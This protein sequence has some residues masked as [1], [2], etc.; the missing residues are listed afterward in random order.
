MSWPTLTNPGLQ[1]DQGTGADPTTGMPVQLPPIV[2]FFKNAALRGHQ[3]ALDEMSQVQPSTSDVSGPVGGPQTAT[4]VQ[5]PDAKVPKFIQPSF[6]QAAGP[7]ANGL[8]QPINPAAET[9]AGALLHILAAAGQGALAG[10]GTGNPAAGADR[11]REIPIHMAQERQQLQTGSLANQTSQAN[12]RAFPLSIAE[13]QAAIE[14][15][16]AQ[17]RLATQGAAGGQYQL[18]PGGA[19]YRYQ[20]TGHFGQPVGPGMSAI[21]PALLRPKVKGVTVK[22]DDGI[23]RAATQNLLTGEIL[24]ENQQVI[25]NAQIF[26]GSM[27]P[28]STTENQSQDL[29]GNTTNR[30]TTTPVLPI[31]GGTAASSG[32]RP[33]NMVQ[34]SAGG[35]LRAQAGT[36]G[37]ARPSVKTNTPAASIAQRPLPP[38]VEQRLT[39]SGLGP[40][41]QSY[42][43]GLLNYQGQL[44][45]PRA[46]N[47]APTLATLTSIDPSFNAANYDANKKTFQDYTPGGTVGKQA[48]AFNTAI[49]HLDML[50][51]A[52]TALKNFDTPLLNKITNFVNVQV[53]NSPVTTFK[54]IADAVDGEVSKTFK[55]T[56]TEGELARVGAHF[57][58]SLAPD[59]IQGNVRSTIGLLNGKMGEMQSA[60]QRQIGRP[61]NMVSPE[62]Q[63]A[64]QRM[65][66]GGATQA[67]PQTHVFSSSA[68]QRANPTGNVSAAK[69]AAANQGYQV[70][71]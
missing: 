19:G 48:I 20:P 37:T 14:Q 7:G 26:E 54:N 17:T 65:S 15:T 24:D 27:V 60:Y 70:Q 35:P 71:P 58:S 18:D 52:A 31:S 3:A 61:I 4:D 12:L 34:H 22:G 53:G 21:P 46:R 49:A 68:W 32:Q 38:D 2:K 50:D 59:Q 45:S 13:R 30:K 55:G 51:Q 44:P 23:P 57:D 10:W 62:A 42:V 33:V 28:K 5:P 67:S 64:I 56:A 66:A 69:A 36:A 40:Q 9:K 25:P 11:A 63:K 43:R 47:Y 1:Y 6:S 39:T 29:M 41:E 8:P 16:L